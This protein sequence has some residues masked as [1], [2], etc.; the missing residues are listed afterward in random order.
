VKYVS[1]KASSQSNYLLDVPEGASF[2]DMVALRGDKDIGEKI[3]KI[4][5]RLA[6]ANDLMGV[7]NVADRAMQ[8]GIGLVL[9]A[10]ANVMPKEIGRWP[11]SLR[12]ATS[13]QSVLRVAGW[14]L[15][16]AGLGYAG[17]WAF[18]P[19][20]FADVAATIVL[21]TATLIAVGYGAWAFFS[22]RSS[23]RRPSI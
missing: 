22:C 6:E 15:T 2:A 12:A 11:T 16:L 9:A 17:L 20:A 14:S 4:I 5:H 18:A 13:S 3:N 19:L 21:A 8:V 10:Y 23:A 1:D 7:I